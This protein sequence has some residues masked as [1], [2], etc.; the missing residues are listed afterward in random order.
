MC[1]SVGVN[2]ELPPDMSVSVA[3]T[4]AT[5][6]SLG[7]DIS[8][9]TT[10]VEDKIATMLDTETTTYA[11]T[12]VRL[13]PSPQLPPSPYLTPPPTDSL[14]KT[15]PVLKLHHQRQLL[16]QHFLERNPLSHVALALLHGCRLGELRCAVAWGCGCG[17]GRGECVFVSA[18]R[19]EEGIFG[20]FGGGRGVL[21]RRG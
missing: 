5:A 19:G 13:P 3:T 4:T 8:A 1:K 20:F 12:S 7:P 9:G 16:K 2:F 17:V 10:T 6:T 15:P 11:W 14:S 18:G 21:Q